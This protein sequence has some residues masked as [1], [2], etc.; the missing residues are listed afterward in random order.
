MA[1][2]RIRQRPSQS[3]SCLSCSGFIAPAVTVIRREKLFAYDDSRW[4][5]VTPFPKKWRPSSRP[6]SRMDLAALDSQRACLR[7]G[8][9]LGDLAP[10]QGI[11]PG[12][13]V[14]GAAVLVAKIIGVFPDVIAHQRTF[15]IHDRIVLIWAGLDRELAVLC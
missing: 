5:R 8:I 13:E 15:A 9:A 4:W 6:F 2:R 11:P 1:A 12:L 14:I 3:I 10:V 7:G